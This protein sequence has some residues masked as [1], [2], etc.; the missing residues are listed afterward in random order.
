MYI[1]SKQTIIYEYG[2]NKQEQLPV[3]FLDACLYK[4]QNC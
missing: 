1:L 4:T 2:A 3:L